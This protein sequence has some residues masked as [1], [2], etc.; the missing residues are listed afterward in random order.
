MRFWTW[1]LVPVQ[2]AEKQWSL[3]GPVRVS[4]STMTSLV[5]SHGLWL[6]T[7]TERD[8]RQYQHHQ[9]NEPLGPHGG[10]LHWA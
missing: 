6:P 7:G 8:H 4:P 5:T 3:W 2:I 10:L 9:C 1:A